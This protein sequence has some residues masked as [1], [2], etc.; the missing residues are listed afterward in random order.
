M[1][2]FPRQSS[3]KESAC[4][5]RGCKRWGF[6][7]QIQKIPWSRKRQFTPV[8][9]PGKSHRQRNLVGYSSWGCKESDTSED[10]C[11]LMCTHARTRA[12]THTHTHTLHMG[13]NIS[14][15]RYIQHYFIYFGF[16]AVE[17]CWILCY[18]VSAEIFCCLVI[19][20][21]I[22]KLLFH[23]FPKSKMQSV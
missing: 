22:L 10:E 12:R 11:V 16:P 13:A 3:G 4:Q 19:L 17:Y 9:L 8:F 7:T 23:T 18:S 21:M 6:D 1:G 2:G 15:L 5:C 14:Q 20:L